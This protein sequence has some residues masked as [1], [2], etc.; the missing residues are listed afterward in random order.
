M[1]T[2]ANLPGSMKLGAAIVALAAVVGAVAL[3]GGSLAVWVALGGFLLVGLALLGYHAVL[4]L[5]A[6]RRAAPMTRALSGNAAASPSGITE[7]ARR[8]RLDD[9][10]KNFEG[11]VDKFHAAG[12][13]LYALP[14]YLLVGEPGSGKTEAIRHC[15]VGFPPGLQDQ[16]QGVGGTLNMN[17]WF[18]NHAVILD[19]AG[20]LMFDEVEP[21]T[22]NEWQEFLKLLKRNRPNCPVNGLLLVI[23]AE[24]LIRDTADAIERKAGKISQQLDNIQ[25]VLGVRFPVFVIITKCDLIVG[26][27][28]F[29]DE[30]TDPA[31]QHQIM[32]WSN[33]APLDTPFQPELVEQHLKSVQARLMRRRMGLLQDPV[34]TDD[35]KLRRA[36][37]VDALYAFPDSML[38]L[39]PRLKSYLEMIFVAGEWSSKPLFLRGIYFTSSMREGSALDAEL[40]EALGVPVE[41]LP[42]GKVWERDRAYFLRDL[43][44]N[45]VFREKGL[46]T[47]ASST[48]SQQRQRRM[49]VVGATALGL[50]AAAGLTWLGWSSLNRTIMRPSAFWTATARVFLENNVPAEP[51]R[52]TSEQFLPIV[53]KDSLAFEEFRYRGA[54]GPDAQQLL[55]VPVDKS[56]LTRGQFPLELRDQA[57]EKVGVPWVFAPIAALTGDSAGN[58]LAT[59]RE[60]AARTLI[61]GSIL[62][63]LVDAAKVRLRND[64]EASSAGSWSLEATGALAQL[65]RLEVAGIPN[66]KTMLPVDLEPLMR[67][68]LKGND[69]FTAK[70]ADKDL[71]AIDEAYKSLFSVSGGTWPPASLRGS[72]AA[73]IAKSAEAMENALSGT[74]TAVIAEDAPSARRLLAALDEFDR[75]DR[76]ITGEATPAQMTALTDAAAKIERDLP[77]LK[78]RTLRVALTD[79]VDG[80]RRIDQLLRELQPLVNADG[81]PST[82]ASN[83]GGEHARIDIL[84]NIQ[85]TLAAR[86]EAMKRDGALSAEMRAMLDRLEPLAFVAGG[87]AGYAARLKARKSPGGGAAPSAPPAPQPVPATAAMPNV[88]RAAQKF[89]FA[90]PPAPGA[91]VEET[92][93]AELASLRAEIDAARQSSTTLSADAARVARMLDA[94]AAPG[95]KL[96]CTVGLLANRASTGG[97][98]PMSELAA[99][100][101]LAGGDVVELGGGA[102]AGAERALGTLPYPGRPVTMTFFDAAG[103]QVVH[104]ET[105]AGAWVPLLLLARNEAQGNG[106]T[107]DVEMVLTVQGEPRSMWLRLVFEKDLPDPLPFRR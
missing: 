83:P 32:G 34:H 12:K 11:G 38:A 104:T 71:R 80:S 85:R 39:A 31:L 22:T 6:Q 43:F 7:P 78:G 62:R 97:R 100:V 86:K 106:K 54:Q 90:P 68:A 101:Q 10:R 94:L 61:E 18:T 88:Q 21:G 55:Q 17:W 73:L 25:R 35:P 64:T 74:Q 87:E 13:N 20:R 92:P 72:N 16:L 58:L 89:P 4:G 14:W 67:Y 75:A 79:E 26:F 23:P 24:S 84:L 52:G 77:M 28:E 82:L 36:D 37:Q 5:M 76:A 45:K 40:A 66:A 15:N 103:T 8:A 42:E 102:G 9:L 51:G 41:S 70:G 49:I 48:T 53:S 60:A 2:V 27:R 59:E 96:T 91:P 19:T 69:D 93:V 56:R 33:P 98:K 1:E 29:F 107:W 63:P 57:S 81:S 99:G 50:A 65:I 44:M 46:V 30:I 105:I 3:F 47:R 95:G